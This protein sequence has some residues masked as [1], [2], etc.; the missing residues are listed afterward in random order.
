[1][2]YPVTV[3]TIYKQSLAAV[4]RRVHIGEVG[5]AWRPALDLVWEFLGRN[6][7]LRTN[8]H[9]V[10]V[11]YSL[12]DNSESIEVEFGVQVTR[13]FKGEGEVIESTTPAGE[14]ASAIANGYDMIGQ[15][16]DTIHKWCAAHGR[17]LSGVSLEIY[18]DPDEN[19][20]TKI[21][22]EVMYLLK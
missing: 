5:N 13:D 3:K 10:F 8:G 15:V 19:D 14:V 21:D 6:P 20:H 1:M 9:N 17:E 18:G 16:H 11:Y 4:R 12:V 22:I 2:H 7:G